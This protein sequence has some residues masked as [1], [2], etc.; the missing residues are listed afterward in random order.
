VKGEAIHTCD[1]KV[2]DRPK[3]PDTRHP[4][5]QK[6]EDVLVVS[7]DRLPKISLFK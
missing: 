2:G 3:M 5:E 1:V 4:K 7:A 6:E